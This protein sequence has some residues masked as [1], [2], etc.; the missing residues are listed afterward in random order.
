MIDTRFSVSVQIMM[1]AAHH[2]DEMVNSE[3]LAAVLQTNPTFIRKVVSRLVEAELLVSFRGKGGGIQLARPANEISLKD[4][5]VAA[6]NE[7]RLVNIHNKPV[8]K[9]CKVS[10]GINDVLEEIVCGIEHSTQNYLA[11]KSLHDLLKKV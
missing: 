11:K 8:T 4:I 1:T 10:C 6:T 7:K 5:Y 3:L 9:H 2:K